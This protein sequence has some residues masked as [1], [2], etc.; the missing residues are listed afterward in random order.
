MTTIFVRRWCGRRSS[1]TPS[2][3]RVGA[4]GVA[5]SRCCGVP[6]VVKSSALVQPSPRKIAGCFDSNCTASSSRSAVAPLRTAPNR[7]VLADPPLSLGW[8]RCR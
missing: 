8:P 3:I 1:E 6:V 2:M 7:D 5:G 4:C